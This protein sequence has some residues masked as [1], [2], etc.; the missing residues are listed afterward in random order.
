MK[1]ITI[2]AAALSLIAS[3][4]SS[5]RLDAGNRLKARN[6]QNNTQPIHES[7][8]EDMMMSGDNCNVKTVLILGE[9]IQWQLYVRWLRNSNSDSGRTRLV[10]SSTLFRRGISGWGYSW[11]RANRIGPRASPLSS[12]RSTCDCGI[13]RV[14]RKR[15]MDVWGWT[16]QWSVHLPRTNEWK[17]HH[18]WNIGLWMLSRL[19]RKTCHHRWLLRRKWLHRLEYSHV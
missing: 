4:Q 18:R 2:L 14:S 16:N 8:G 17:C 7:S 9:H 1:A 15:G 11:T 19:H 12:I 3:S 10:Q 5:A 13:I 6:L